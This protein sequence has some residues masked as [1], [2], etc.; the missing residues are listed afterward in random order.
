MKSM[1][2]RGITGLER[3]KETMDIAGHGVAFLHNERIKFVPVLLM[4]FH[5]LGVLCLIYL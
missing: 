5:V 4:N 3:V 2:P 1:M